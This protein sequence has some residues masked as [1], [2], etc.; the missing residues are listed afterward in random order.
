MKRLLTSLRLIYVILLV[1]VACSDHELGLNRPTDIGVAVAPSSIPGNSQANA[2]PTQA[3]SG[4]SNT[5]GV[6]IPTGDAVIARIQNGIEKNA[7]PTQGNFARGIQQVSTNLPHVT[8]VLNASGF[9]QIELLAYAACSDLVNGPMQ[10]TYGV[11]PS[12]TITANQAALVAAGMRMLDQH[13]AGLASQGPAAAQLT[14]ILT[15]LVQSEASIATGTS[16][17]AFMTVCI[18]VNT[19]GASMLGL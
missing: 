19:A 2:G 17:T 11:N 18:A 6:V 14:T 5:L 4:G 15:N 3:V 1:T 12:G 13:T 16:T 10:N 9:D 8:N 7:D